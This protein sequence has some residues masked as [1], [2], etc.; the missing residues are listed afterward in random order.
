MIEIVGWVGTRLMLYKATRNRS[1]GRYIRVLV[2]IDFSQ[3]LYDET[4][5]KWE[6]YAFYTEMVYEKLPNYC[7][8][9]K[10]IGHAINYF[11][12][13]IPKNDVEVD[14]T[15]KMMGARPKNTTK[16]IEKR[17][18]L[19]FSS[20]HIIN[21][22]TPIIKETLLLARMALVLTRKTLLLIRKT[23]LLPRKAFV[24]SRMIQLLSRKTLLLSRKTLHLA[25]KAFILLKKTH[26]FYK[27]IIH[28]NM[29]RI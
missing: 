16:Y 13:L 8:H 19:N 28:N 12:K 17:S 18:N 6:G 3:R 21:D 24:L 22:D 1:F 2:D 29:M 27:S 15:T 7:V 5:V 26:L 10:A 4:M 14:Q 9:C 23:H 20:L 11:H 25:R